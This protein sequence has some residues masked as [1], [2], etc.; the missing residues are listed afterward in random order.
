MDENI[1]TVE[2][3]AHGLVSAWNDTFPEDPINDM[4]DI[5]LDKMKKLL[6]FYM[7][8]EHDLPPLLAHMYAGDVVTA[9]EAGE[10]G[11]H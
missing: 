4:Y 5:P 9:L 1:A 11:L 10:N 6:M 8:L 2:G 7:M 3:V